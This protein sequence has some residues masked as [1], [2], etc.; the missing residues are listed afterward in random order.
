MSARVVLERF[1][2]ELAALRPAVEALARHHHDVAPALGDA[3]DPDDLWA[4]VEAK[5]RRGRERGGFEVV[6][7]TGDR[8]VGVVVGE[9][10]EASPT[11]DEGWS[12]WVVTMLTVLGPARGA[13][14]GARLLDAFE[15]EAGADELRLEVL[16]ANEPA[17]RFYEREGF[18]VRTLEL[19]R[20]ARGSG[21]PR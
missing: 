5:L 1:D 10:A 15:R 17:R 14:L 4:M 3:R 20:F 16:E 11:F 12:A 19:S 9:P 21:P 7:R 2:G 6:A 18:A 8:V 13:G